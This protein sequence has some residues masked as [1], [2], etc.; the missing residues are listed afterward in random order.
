M[1]NGVSLKQLS[2]DLKRKI[3]EDNV[4]NGGAAL[5]YYLTLSIFPALILLMTIIPYLPI[6]QV[7]QSIMNALGQALPAEASEMVAGVVQEVTADRKGGLLSL[8]LVLT[9]WAAS[10]GMYAIMKQ[11]N[12]TYGARE[13]RNF[14]HGRAVALALSVVFILLVIGASLLIVL[15]ERIQAW[16]GLGGVMLAVFAVLRWLVIVALLLAALAIIYRY[17]PNV[18]HRFAFVTPG[19]VFASGLLIL[20]SLGFS[21]YVNNFAN[22]SATY[23]SIGA[24]IVLMLWLYIAGLVILVGS[25]INVLLDH[26]GRVG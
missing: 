23:G 8:G 1:L 22:Y 12:I 7:E 6:A 11:L 16:L 19:S 9:L 5:A 26:Y 4:F 17:G 20:A 10:T 15:G 18:K 3:G 24:V 13:K 21:F 25:E 2:I 14:L